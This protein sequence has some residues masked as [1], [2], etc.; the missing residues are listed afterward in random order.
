[1]KLRLFRE[2]SVL[3]LILLSVTSSHQRTH[4]VFIDIVGSWKYW[5]C[6]FAFSVE[7][8]AS[9]GNHF[10]RSDTRFRYKKVVFWPSFGNFLAFSWF[11][12]QNNLETSF[13]EVLSYDFMRICIKGQCKKLHVH[14]QTWLILVNN[15]R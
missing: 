8:F 14:L 11:Q 6:I 5:I 9:F 12:N 7:G 3:L 2:S 13:A 15:I 4:Q 10:N 1:M